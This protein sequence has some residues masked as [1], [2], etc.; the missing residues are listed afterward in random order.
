MICCCCWLLFFCFCFLHKSYVQICL[1]PFSQL[2]FNIYFTSLGMKH[3]CTTVI[4]QTLFCGK[5][6]YKS[7]PLSWEDTGF[8]SS[9]C[10]EIR[11]RTVHL[12]DALVSPTPSSSPPSLGEE[13]EEAASS[14]LIFP[15]IVLLQKK[16]VAVLHPRLFSKPKL[17]F[18]ILCHFLLLH[19][20]AAT[21]CLCWITNC[22]VL[23]TYLFVQSITNAAGGKCQR[24]HHIISARR[25]RPA[26]RETC[27]LRATG[28]TWMVKEKFL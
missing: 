7:S 19:I 15:P 9:A 6:R 5:R 22:S 11:L 27:R 28:R 24:A 17:F 3:V 18:L 4:V 1:C 14:T 13:E 12:T 2:C 26:E 21:D 25:R 16:K 8:Y 23:T 20:K 10:W